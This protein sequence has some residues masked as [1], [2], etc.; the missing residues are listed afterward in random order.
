ME[1][2]KSAVGLGTEREDVAEVDAEEDVDR[3][4]KEVDGLG[5]AK[6]ERSGSVDPAEEEDLEKDR[7]KCDLESE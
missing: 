6:D 1:R 7:E 3:T 4:G 5:E 2:C